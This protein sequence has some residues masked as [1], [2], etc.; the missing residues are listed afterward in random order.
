MPVPQQIY[1]CDRYGR[2][3][4]LDPA[5]L[6][7]S[8]VAAPN[9]LAPSP[10]PALFALGY[11]TAKDNIYMTGLPDGT[12]FSGIAGD[13]TGSNLYALRLVLNGATYTPT[14]VAP[15]TRMVGPRP[16]WLVVDPTGG[17]LFVA[18]AQQGLS[19]WNTTATVTGFTQLGSN[20]RPGLGALQAQGVAFS[21]A[22]N[23]IYVCCQSATGA[24][25]IAVYDG[26]N[27][28]SMLQIAGSP[29]AFPSLALNSSRTSMLVVGSRLV[30]TTA[31]GVVAFNITATTIALV[32]GSPFPTSATA[33]TQ[34]GADPR[35][36]AFD[37]INNR[38]LVCNFGQNSVA[39]LN[40]TSYA[41]MASSPFPTAQS[42]KSVIFNPTT[43]R[44]YVA[45]FNGGDLTAAVPTSGGLSVYTASTMAQIAGSPFLKGTP[46][47]LVT[48]GP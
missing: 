28:A 35:G 11:D 43:A 37:S 4:I 12:S 20:Y 9:I 18:D 14:E 34:L 29:F 30:V 23:R 45:N 7:L 21:S 10:G 25:Q 19:V 44:V 8:T 42:P 31:A 38:I 46:T 47:S 2:L 3:E 26:T 5:S 27:S 16:E 13:P 40:S 6:A 17:R 32:A 48:F 22:L 1:C 36:L 39:A 41:H 24:D 33:A 15:P